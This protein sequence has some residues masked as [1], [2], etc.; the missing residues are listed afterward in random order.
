MVGDRL[1]KETAPY[2]VDAWVK[3][4]FVGATVTKSETPL[5]RSQAIGAIKSGLAGR[6]DIGGDS[7]LDP[8]ILQ[9]ALRACIEM[10]NQAAGVNSAPALNVA[11]A[12][13]AATLAGHIIAHVGRVTAKGG[14]AKSGNEAQ[15]RD[16]YAQLVN[17]AEMVIVATAGVVDPTKPVAQ[18]KIGDP[19]K[20]ATAKDDATVVTNCRELVGSDG[21]LSKSPWD[22]RG[23]FKSP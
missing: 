1:T 16:A 13:D 9:A 5:L 20:A 7:V 2:T 22:L 19:L 14:F 12:K 23:Q 8:V 3:A 4:G 17:S 10:R 18:R 6:T 21:L 15:A 11:G